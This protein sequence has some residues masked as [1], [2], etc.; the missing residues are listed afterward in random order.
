MQRSKINKFVEN[1]PELGKETDTKLQEAQRILSNMNYIFGNRHTIIN[2]SK[3]KDNEQISKA[4]REK[5][6][7]IY[8]GN[9]TRVSV[10]FSADSLQNRKERN[11]TIKTLKTKQNKQKKTLLTKNTLPSED[12]LQK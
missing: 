3:V 4:A 9:P 1:V 12:V 7:V 8:R 2:F 11:D 5:Q 6:F 10:N